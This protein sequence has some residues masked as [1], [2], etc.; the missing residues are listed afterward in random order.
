MINAVVPWFGSKRTL[1]AEIVRQLGPHRAYWEPCCASLAVLLAKPPTAHETVSDLHGDVI[2]LPVGEQGQEVPVG[3]TAPALFRNVEDKERDKQPMITDTLEQ[4]FMQPSP[5][6]KLFILSQKT[7]PRLGLS[8][9]MINYI[10]RPSDIK[11]V[12][13]V[14]R[15]PE[16]L[17]QPEGSRILTPQ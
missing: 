17:V 13:F 10:V 15:M 4:V 16:R 9:A 2:N 3:V 12:S 11:S 6:G 7:D 14:G 8:G 1:A 5:C